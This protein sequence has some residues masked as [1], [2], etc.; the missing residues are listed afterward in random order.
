M[1]TMEL[2][3][4]LKTETI[5][6]Q[7]NFTM[8][9]DPAEPFVELTIPPGGMVL[10]LEPSPTTCLTQNATLPPAPAPTISNLT[11]T[12]AASNELGTTF[13][14]LE[15]VINGEQIGTL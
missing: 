10:D 15:T 7:A 14:W 6:C 5:A 4:D 9:D 8:H 13:P 12:P 11:L 2:S 3:I 1:H